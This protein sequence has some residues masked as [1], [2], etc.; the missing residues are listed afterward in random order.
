ME[1][2]MAIFLFLLGF[3]FGCV[4]STLVVTADEIN[5]GMD[6]YYRGYMDGW[7]EAGGKES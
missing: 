3:A 2:Y 1:V 7:R 6:D 5:N 4:L